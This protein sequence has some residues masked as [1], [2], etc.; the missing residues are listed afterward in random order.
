MEDYGGVDGYSRIPVYLKASNDNKA[1][2]VHCI[3]MFSRG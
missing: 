1:S 3:N 2:T